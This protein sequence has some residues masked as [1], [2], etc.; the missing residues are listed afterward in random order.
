MRHRHARLLEGR[1]EE[2]PSNNPSKC[3]S[4]QAGRALQT[5]V[6]TMLQ[7]W[8][9]L[10]VLQARTASLP[11]WPADR[12]HRQSAAGGSILNSCLLHQDLAG[13]ERGAAGAPCANPSTPRRVGAAQGSPAMLSST[14][15]RLAAQAAPPAPPSSSRRL[16]P[17]CQAAGL[18]GPP[19]QPGR[20]RV[21]EQSPSKSRAAAAAAAAAAPQLDVAAAA[22][23]KPAAPLPPRRPVQAGNVVPLMRPMEDRL[24]QEL[25]QLERHYSL[26][27]VPDLDVSQET[28][29]WRQRQQQQQPAPQQQQQD[30]AEAALLER[31]RQ[32]AE[33]STSGRG[34]AAALQQQQ[35]SGEVV[36]STRSSRGRPAGAAAAR[37]HSSLPDSASL[38]TCWLH[39]CATRHAHGS[40]PAA[41]AAATPAAP[42][43]PAAAQAAV[44]A[45]ASRRRLLRPGA[46]PAVPAADGVSEET[47]QVGR[48]LG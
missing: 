26:P 42:A 22:G 2:R 18:G 36:A 8:K 31:Q 24:Q 12:P 25:A 33:A 11:T 1:R 37:R 5:H 34:L 29:H 39:N 9:A 28:E 48:G 14:G 47:R 46:Q 44:A 43:A 15:S 40:Q 38:V 3:G 6:P 41:A 45:A 17:R 30:G 21:R 13:S 7:R 16:A 10:E 27:S 23:S 20:Q 32:A 4:W 35:R 19:Y